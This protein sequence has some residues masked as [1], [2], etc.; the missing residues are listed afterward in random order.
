V[1]EDVEGPDGG[2]IAE[3]TEG[4]EGLIR[5]FCAAHATIL[6]AAMLVSVV[7]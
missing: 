3:L 4:R 1:F 2:V 7:G 5:Q 6:D